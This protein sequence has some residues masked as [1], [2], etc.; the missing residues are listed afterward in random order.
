MAV[1]LAVDIMYRGKRNDVTCLESCY[2]ILHYILSK[3]SDVLWYGW[4]MLFLRIVFY[5]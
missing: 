4:S 2:S 3:Y 1:H 5:K